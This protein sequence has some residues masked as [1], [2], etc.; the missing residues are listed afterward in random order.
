M[1]MRMMPGV[2]L[3]P[4]LCHSPANVRQAC[5]VSVIDACSSGS[6]SIHRINSSAREQEE[7]RNK[8][9]ADDQ[10]EEGDSGTEDG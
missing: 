6:T 2:C 9:T 1:P 4:C 7:V 3:S 10:K 5:H 8:T